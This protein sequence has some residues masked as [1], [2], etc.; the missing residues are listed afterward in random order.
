[1]GGEGEG[2]GK[3]FGGLIVEKLVCYEATDIFFVFVR[4]FLNIS[5]V[6][7]K[8]MNVGFYY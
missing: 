3:G 1:M 6:P 7:L 4:F 8:T 5:Y 2:K